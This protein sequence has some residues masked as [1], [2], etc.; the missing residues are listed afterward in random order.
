MTIHIELMENGYSICH[1]HDCFFEGVKDWSLACE[2]HEMLSGEL[3][4]DG[5]EF[6]F[7]PVTR[8]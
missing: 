4:E 2:I 7:C 1:G 3:D 8:R 6:P 5:A